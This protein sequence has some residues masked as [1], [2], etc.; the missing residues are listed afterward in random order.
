M[1][2]LAVQKECKVKP[3]YNIV[4]NKEN[5]YVFNK[6]IDL[7][8]SSNGAVIFNKKSMFPTPQV[9][10]ET[11]QFQQDIRQQLPLLEQQ[12]YTLLGEVKQTFEQAIKTKLGD[13]SEL[14]G[15]LNKLY[16]RLI[17]LLHRSII[18]DNGETRFFYNNFNNIK[19]EGADIGQH[20]FYN[21]VG[22]S[23]LQFDIFKNYGA[24]KQISKK[25]WKTQKPKLKAFDA[26]ACDVINDIDQQYQQIITELN[27]TIDK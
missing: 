4:I 23:I 21:V 8:I 19:K 17:K 13:D 7:I 24:I 10:K 2:L 18:T 6:K 25:E 20:I 14:H 1:T 11:K 22:S 5:V 26:H 9:I 3:S 15:Q 27:K 12:A 16:K